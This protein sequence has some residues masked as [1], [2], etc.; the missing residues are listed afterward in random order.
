[1]KTNLQYKETI[2]FSRLNAGDGFILNDIYYMK[3]HEF[4][5]ANAVNLKSGACYFIPP[6]MLVENVDLEVSVMFD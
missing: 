6:D 2:E 5:K 3:I 4:S 1:M